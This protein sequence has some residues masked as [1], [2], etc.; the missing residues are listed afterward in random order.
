MLYKIESRTKDED[1]S[2]DEE[3][4]VRGDAEVPRV[5]AADFRASLSCLND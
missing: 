1:K 3:V 4:D 5:A 2:M